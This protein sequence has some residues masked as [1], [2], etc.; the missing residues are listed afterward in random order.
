M[1]NNLLRQYLED[2]FSSAVEGMRNHNFS[3]NERLYY[4]SAT[5]GSLSRVL[6]IEYSSSFVFAHLVLQTT[7]QAMLQIIS[8]TF[9]GSDSALKFHPVIIDSLSDLIED[10]GDELLNQKS[11]YNTL[12]K[13]SEIAFSMT[14]NGNYLLRKKVIDISM[15]KSF[16]SNE[17]L[18]GSAEE[19]TSKQDK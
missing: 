18:E 17:Y 3:L 19:N 12:E 10:L 2:E 14:G 15:P 5:F 7:H 4:M 9:N 1:T 6:N 13:I 8:K 16:E 11:T